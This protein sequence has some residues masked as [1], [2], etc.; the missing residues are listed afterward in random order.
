MS[1]QL[2]TIEQ[3]PQ[4]EIADFQQFMAFKG[5]DGYQGNDG[6]DGTSILNRDA[7]ASAVLDLTANDI[8]VK[9]CGTNQQFEITNEVLKAF[10]MIL[11]GG[12]LNA[13]LFTH[14]TKSI[15]FT[16]QVGTLLSDY[17]NTVSNYLACM[18]DNITESA[19]TIR[20]ILYV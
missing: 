10:E 12:T 13:T 7:T 4:N 14:A 16:M 9:T 1:E 5:Q 6:I 18:I 11:T 20:G 15:T 19:I 17:N 3:I 2:I 8:F